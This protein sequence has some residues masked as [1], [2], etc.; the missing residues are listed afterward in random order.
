MHERNASRWLLFYVHSSRKQCSCCLPNDTD[1]AS[2]SALYFW[3]CHTMAGLNEKF[4]YRDD[5][6]GKNG[7]AKQS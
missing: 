2:G 7:V 1:F 3:S 6:N 4:L 5:N